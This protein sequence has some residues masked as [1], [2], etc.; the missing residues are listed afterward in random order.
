[1]EVET[2]WGQ[3]TEAHSNY[4]MEK[5]ICFGLSLGS[6]NGWLLLSLSNPLN[7]PLWSLW[8]TDARPHCSLLTVP[9]VECLGSDAA[10]EPARGGWGA[11]SCCPRQWGWWLAMEIKRV[12]R[13][14]EAWLACCWGLDGDLGGLHILR[15][16]AEIAKLDGFQLIWILNVKAVVS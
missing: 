3:G 11:H 2:S 16:E 4:F 14:S 1:M 8:L 15:N 9:W 12:C 7:L 6:S 5:G 13:H 10:V